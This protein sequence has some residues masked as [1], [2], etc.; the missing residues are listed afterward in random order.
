MLTKI[1]NFLLFDGKLFTCLLPLSK[2]SDSK[3]FFSWSL[4][5]TAV[6]EYFVIGGENFLA[7]PGA[8]YIL[9]KS[10][11][12][13]LDIMDQD[14][15][16]GASSEGNKFCQIFD[17]LNFQINPRNYNLQYIQ[18]TLQLTHLLRNL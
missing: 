15:L 14:D 9:N 10:E 11:E 17:I 1:L 2:M 16:F 7:C 13:L 6:L 12:N 3:Q 8:I 18:I 5:E 4:H